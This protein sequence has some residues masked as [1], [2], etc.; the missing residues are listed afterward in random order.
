MRHGLASALCTLDP[1]RP[2][3]PAD[4]VTAD[5]DVG[6]LECLPGAAVAVG[7]VVGGVDLLDQGEQALVLDHARGSPPRSPLV[8]GGG[9][10]PEGAADRL[11]PEVGT[12]IVH[13][14]AHLGRRWSSSVAKK[15]DAE[16]RSPFARRSS[17]TSPRSHFS[18][19]RRRS[20]ASASAS[21]THL[22]SDSYSIPTGR[23]YFLV[24]AWSEILLSPGRERPGVKVSVKPSLA[25]RAEG[26]PTIGVP[27]TQTTN[28]Q[29]REPGSP[30]LYRVTSTS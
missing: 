19:S 4:V 6:A 23:G 29:Q 10:D 18:S 20:S 15:T 24:S 16:R 9:T 2:H 7:G 3:Q 21:R 8:V 17:L 11:D 1:V 12:P 14:G 13:E 30:M 27:S 28:S 26:S 5:L 22:R 25:Q